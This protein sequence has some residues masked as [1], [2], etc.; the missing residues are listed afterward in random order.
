VLL[1][2]FTVLLEYMECMKPDKNF[3]LF[4]GVSVLATLL[5]ITGMN[6]SGIVS[7]T[8]AQQLGGEMF[9]EEKGKIME[10]KEIGPNKAEVSFKSNGTLKGN[11][12]VTNSG[13][14]EVTPRV[15]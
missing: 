15:M 14:F 6:F 7:T 1:I 11:I 13:N 9:F 10:Q 2:K 12:E 8:Y 4:L 3:S 5:L